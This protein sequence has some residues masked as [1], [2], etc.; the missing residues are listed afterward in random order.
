MNNNLFKYI[1][2][3]REGFVF[4][5]KNDKKTIFS[6]CRKELIEDFRLDKNEFVNQWFTIAYF[7]TKPLNQSDSS[8]NVFIISDMKLLKENFVPN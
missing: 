1:G 4:V 3:V 8:G 7:E 5:D 6:K 2:L